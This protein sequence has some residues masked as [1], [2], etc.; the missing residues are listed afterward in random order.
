MLGDSGGAKPQELCFSSCKDTPTSRGEA[1]G[2][3]SSLCS[4]QPWPK[5]NGSLKKSSLLLFLFFVCFPLIIISPYRFS[6]G[7][8]AP[9]VLQEDVLCVLVPFLP[10]FSPPPFKATPQLHPAP[11]CCL[12]VLPVLDYG[13]GNEI[14]SAF[15]APHPATQDRISTF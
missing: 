10:C 15:S 5:A 13:C 14:F 1:Q 7:F 3:L 4:F 11:L 6:A 9:D 2:L 8:P 12:P